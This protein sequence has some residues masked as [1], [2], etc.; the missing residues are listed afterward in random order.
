MI[1][2]QQRQR[3]LLFDLESKLDYEGRISSRILS[4]TTASS[5]ATYNDDDEKI[6]DEED[7]DIP[8]VTMTAPHQQPQDVV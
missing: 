7:D 4:T 3:E 5:T 8:T 6:N 1:D 2:E